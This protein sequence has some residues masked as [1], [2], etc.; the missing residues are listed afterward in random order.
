MMDAKKIN[1]VVQ[2]VLA[3]LPPGFKN[4]PQDIEANFRAALIA[5]L[6]KLDIVTREE[7]DAQTGVL[8][9]TR[10]KLEELEKKIKAL[11]KQQ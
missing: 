5:A 3:S 4:L 2:Q 10:S 11:E 6:Q 8:L 1:E 9:R 7:F